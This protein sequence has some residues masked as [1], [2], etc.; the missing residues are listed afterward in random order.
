VV[1]LFLSPRRVDLLVDTLPRAEWGG[2]F[3]F[4]PVVELFLNPRP[5]SL[6]CSNSREYPAEKRPENV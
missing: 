1:E 2:A 6:F 3:L 4:Y 5:F